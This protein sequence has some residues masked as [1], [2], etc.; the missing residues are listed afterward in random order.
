MADRDP[1]LTDEELDRLD[2]FLLD[3]IDEGAVTE[4]KDEGVLGISE[5]DGFL[6]AIVSG[7]V[8][9]VPSRWL[10]AV[11]GDFEPGWE[12]LDEAGVILALLVGHMNGI[13]DCLIQEPENFEPIFMETVTRDGPVLVVDAWCEGY[14]RGVALTADEWS[15]AGLEIADLLAPIR[16]FTDETS[17]LAHEL[18]DPK[19]FETLRDAITPNAR[20]IH[21]YWLRLRGT[22]SPS[23]TP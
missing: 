23:A 5:L 7:P 13:A 9:V 1:S 11:Y 19:Q 3:R 14:V 20:A 22:G 15:S 10:P 6:T 17:W 21:A 18:D 4:G 2:S 16:A 8:P 12:D